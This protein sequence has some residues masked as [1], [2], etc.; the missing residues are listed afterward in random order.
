MVGPGTGVAPFRS[1]INENVANHIGDKTTLLLVFGSRNQAADFHC[2]K[3]WEKLRDDGLL[4]LL[5][6]FSRDQAHKM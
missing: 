1:I 6:A 5:T 2:S 3:E 4:T